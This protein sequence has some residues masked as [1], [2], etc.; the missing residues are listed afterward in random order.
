M[1]LAFEYLEKPGQ[2]TET[3]YP[4]TSGHGKTGTCNKAKEGGDVHTTGLT[5]VRRNSPSQL[6][7]A[8]AKTVVSVAIEADKTVF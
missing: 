1:A 5:S 6:N 3:A 2:N 7:A 4:Y 8:I